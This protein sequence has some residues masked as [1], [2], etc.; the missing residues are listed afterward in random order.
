MF[1]EDN[2]PPGQVNPGH[3]PPRTILMRVIAP[4]RLC[5]LE[6]FY[7]LSFRLYK[8][9]TLKLHELK[10]ATFVTIRYFLNINM[11]LS[12]TYNMFPFRI[13]S[14]TIEFLSKVWNDFEIEI[15]ILKLLHAFWHINKIISTKIQNKKYS[16]VVYSI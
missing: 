10:H 16:R 13:I 5:C 3:L 1:S 2:W 4:R 6:I 15:E 11:H 12:K 8:K 14:K 9:I 7:C